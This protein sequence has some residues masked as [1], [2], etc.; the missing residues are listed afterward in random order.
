MSQKGLIVTVRW[1]LGIAQYPASTTSNLEASLT[2]TRASVLHKMYWLV[3][4]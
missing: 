2:K 4:S 3:S 1:C